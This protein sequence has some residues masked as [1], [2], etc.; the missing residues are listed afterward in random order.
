MLLFVLRQLTQ[1]T[2]VYMRNRYGTEQEVIEV[3]ESDLIDRARNI[4]IQNLQPFFNS[5]MFK[6][7][8]FSYDSKRKLIVQQM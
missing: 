8:N 6:A 5:D 2:A 7:N 4:N 3:A 1:E